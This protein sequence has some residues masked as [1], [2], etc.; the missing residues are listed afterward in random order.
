MFLKTIRHKG[1]SLRNLLAYMI[2][3]MQ[4][5]EDDLMVV[6]NL[7]SFDQS[8]IMQEFIANDHYYRK[9]SKAK[10]RWYH[11]ILSIGALDHEKVDA[12]MLERIAQKYIQM[13]SPNAL[14]FAVS[15]E[16]EAHKHIHFCFSGTEYRNKK[17][18]RMDNK[19]F[20]D[21]RIGLEKWQQ[22]ELPELEHSIVYLNSE[23]EKRKNRGTGAALQ[24]EYQTKKRLSGTSS[25]TV[26]EQLSSTVQDMFSCSRT[27]QQFYE[28]LYTA[29]FTVYER[30]GT[31]TGV[32]GKKKYRFKTLGITSDMILSLD[33]FAKRQ[34][35]VE[36][37]MSRDDEYELER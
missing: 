17:T 34:K 19:T 1:P 26:K 15:H 36:Q 33:R 13:R 16:G 11:E 30:N 29:G 18:L 37:L 25:M 8:A 4:N 21:L 10:V 3:G 12:K 31:V 5:K 7:R 6:H 32:V 28:K 9:Q 14:C 24:R 2:D 20:R 23:K 35:D 27:A 22:K